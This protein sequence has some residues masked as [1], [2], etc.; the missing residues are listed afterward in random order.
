MKES[1]VCSI[2]GAVLTKD[3]AKEFQGNYY[4]EECLESNT[5]IC[6]ECGDR[7]WSSDMRNDGIIAIC[8]SCYDDDY[9]S[10]TSC[11]RIVRSND[12][13][14][15][16]D[17]DNPY[18]YH[19]YQK[20]EENAIKSY[21]YKPTPIFYGVGG[22]FMGIELEVDKGG[23][24]HEN[25]QTLIDIAGSDKL[26]CKHDGSIDDG[27]EMVS[28]PMTLEYHMKEMPWR[29]IF[30]KAI[31]MHYRSHQ[32]DTCG[33]H[34]HVNKS[35]LGA[36]YEE[37]EETISHIVYFV[38]KFWAEILKLSRRTQRNIDRWA[39]RYGISTTAKD[40][41]KNA[42]NKGRGRYCA[43]N[44][45]NYNTIEFRFY[46]GSL[47]FESFIAALQ[48]TEEICKTAKSLTDAEMETLSWSDFVV[49]IDEC[50]KPEL[51]GY[52]KEKLLYIN[53]RVS[54]QEEI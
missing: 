37:Q 9:N 44:I 46:R 19:C 22:L 27:F 52:L 49:G 36:T 38:E 17:D 48:L 4:C 41:Y 14:Y 15:E 18:C 31:E 43:I 35:A 5:N 39:S 40:T 29:E 10:C 47:R 2:C 12:T 16:D 53:E 6:D 50:H 25:A 30:E 20:L 24:I 51:I 13:Y 23:E 32:T 7:Y 45:E 8:S 42:K 26:Y 33:L 3:E 34:V 1:K 21:N 11:G 54:T 28:H